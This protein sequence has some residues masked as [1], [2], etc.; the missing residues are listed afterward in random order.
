MRVAGQDIVALSEHADLLSPMTYAHMVKQPPLWVHEI[1]EDMHIKTASPVIPSI[2]VG[3]AYLD[4]EFDLMEFRETVE[5]ALKPPSGGLILW[6]WERL[7]AEPEKVELF[8]DI[9]KE[10]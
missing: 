5:E 2:Q 4:N 8:K 6:S 9:L 10:Y 3:L 1:T 7:I